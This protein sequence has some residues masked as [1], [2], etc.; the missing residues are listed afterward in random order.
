MQMVRTASE[1]SVRPDYSQ[2]NGNNYLG[3]LLRCISSHEEDLVSGGHYFAGRGKIATL[4][5]CH[6]SVQQVCRH[7]DTRRSC[8]ASCSVLRQCTLLTQSEQG[9]PLN[10]ER[11][12]A[13]ACMKRTKLRVRTKCLRAGVNKNYPELRTRYFST[14]K[15]QMFTTEVSS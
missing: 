4:K 9:S 15:A 6:V 8:V 2:V 13:R 10:R 12:T 5:Q 7:M 11:E 1:L 14:L 3:T